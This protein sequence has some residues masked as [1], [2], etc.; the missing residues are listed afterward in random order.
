MNKRTIRDIE[1]SGKRILVRVDFNVPLQDGAVADD[2]RIRAALPTLSYLLDRDAALILCSHLGR[3]T[4][5]DP[6]FSMDRVATRLGKLLGRPVKKAG[7]VVGPEVQAASDAL[8]PGQIL[9]LENTRFEPGEKSNDP[10]LA[11]QLAAL[12]DVYVNDAF[13]SA[14]RAHASTEGAAQAMRARGAPAVAGFLLERELDYLGSVVADPDHPFV[15]I[16]GGAKISGKIDVIDSLLDQVDKLLI[17]G[18]LANTFLQ[19]TGLEVGDSLIED[20]K[21]ELA[22]DLIDRGGEK[23]V[24]PSDAV[25]ADAFATDANVRNVPVTDVPSGWRIMDIGLATVQ[26][27]RAALLGAQTVVWN[28]PMGVFEFPRFAAGTLAVAQLLGQITQAGGRTIVGG[29][30]SASAL[31]QLGLTDAISHI[32]T[33]GGASLELLEGKT[34]PAVA[35]LEDK[36]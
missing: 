34:L 3:P 12:A 8:E 19:A 25:I 6:A 28:G 27:F 15:A 33:G 13:G 20:D 26:R 29:G 7:A 23:L 24:L 11:A 17:G 9:L 10:E 5:V 36:A 35:A 16:I 31:K 21:V 2:T 32:S 4:G 14:H 18:G 1:V 30:D 22:S